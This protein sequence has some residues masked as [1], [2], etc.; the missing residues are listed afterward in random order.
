MPVSP[1]PP[2]D[3]WF[4]VA[5]AYQ[6]AEIR[7]LALI[8]DRLARGQT[9]DDIAWA[10]ARLAEV[11]ELTREATALLARVNVSEANQ[12]LANLDAAYQ[13]GEASALKDAREFAPG[14]ASAVSSVARRASVQSVAQSVAAGLS[15]SLPSLLRRIQDDYATVVRRTVAQQQAGGGDRRQSTQQALNQLFGKGLK[16]GPENSRG[17][18]MTLPDYVTMAVRTGVANTSIQGH[19]DAIGMA[20]LDLVY[21]NPGPRHCEI[22]D[23]WANKP[24]WRSTGPVGWQT[25]EDLTT[26][27]QTRVYVYGTLDQAKAAGW[28]HPNCRCSVGAYLPG[29]TQ[30][31]QPRPKWDEKG[32]EAQ[33]KQRTIERGIR[34][35]KTREA[36]AITDSERARSTAKVREWQGTLR[37]HLKS[38]P[39]LK[40]QS[41]REQV[42]TRAV[43][44]PPAS[45]HGATP[46]PPTA[47]R[48]P[49]RAPAPTP[50]PK[51]P[52]NSSTVTRAVPAKYPDPRGV[53]YRKMSNAQKLEAVRVMYG[54]N[55][56]QYRTAKRRWG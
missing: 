11:Q 35:W 30:L 6:D 33:Q 54:A 43:P 5:Q 55:S 51:P 17:A 39:E 22:C 48:T 28:G 25:M 4:E 49:P 8:R 41:R 46:R 44:R 14:R 52:T 53:D 29:A 37:Q 32:Y 21:I 16:M 36:L 12:I 7:I 38:N 40:R 2:E 3:Y 20:G 47:P 19:L 18:R 42:T 23:Q 27:K 24:L 26:G 1:T 34:S 50:A 31:P 10:T 15:Q 45:P 56:P 13:S 9:L